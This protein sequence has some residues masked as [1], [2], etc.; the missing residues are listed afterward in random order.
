M[1]HV[2]RFTAITFTSAVVIGLAALPAH[3]DD[4]HPAAHPGYRLVFEAVNVTS[5]ANFANTSSL[6]ARCYASGGFCNIESG[7]SAAIDISLSVGADRG[8]IAGSLGVSASSA[9][10]LTVGCR[11]PQLAD[12]QAW[13]AYPVGTRFSYRIKRS[14]YRGPKPS[15]SYSGYLSAFVP[16]PN[17]ISCR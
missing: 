16:Y 15:I 2:R 5:T 12:G 11:S 6:I 1:R 8:S 14:E 10:S 13:S 9:V 7:R 3:A 4:R 17:Q